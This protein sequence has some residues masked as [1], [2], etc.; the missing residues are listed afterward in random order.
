[1]ELMIGI[2]LLGMISISVFTL[3]TTLIR[4]TVITKRKAIA[5][6]LAIS[7][8]EALKALP[9]NSL[10]VAGGPIYSTT[11]LPASF[12]TTLNNISYTTT[13]AINYVDDAFD[14]CGSYPTLAL[15]QLYCRNYPPPTGTPATDTNPQDY[16]IANVTVFGPG[17][18]KLA[19]V[20]SQISA[21]VAETASSTGALFVSVLDQDGNPLAGATVQVLNTTTTPNINLSDTSD[22]NGTAI[23]YGLPPDTTGYDYNITGSLANYSTLSTIAPTGSLVPNYS[24]QRILT[25]QSSSVTLTLKAQGED[26]LVIE[27][28]TTTGAVLAGVKVYVKGGYKKY[29]STT[30]TSYYYDNMAPSDV[31]PT[32]DAGGLTS[33][34][35]LVPGPYV[36]CGELANSNCKIGNTTYYA[37]AV[38]PYGGINPF[39]P[40]TV[41]T[42]L[43]SSPPAVTY[44]YNGTEYLQKVRLMLTT[45][46]SF[47]RI[48]SLSPDDVSLSTSPLSSFSFQ[49]KGANLPCTGSPGT[50]STSVRF[51]QGSTTFTASCTGSGTGILL[52]CTVN[53]TGLTSAPTFLSVTSGGNTLSVPAGSYLGGLIVSP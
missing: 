13:T 17:N 8:M 40:I 51:V 10:A 31:R 47:P 20:D 44:N 37:A 26:S 9:F 46:S 5:S 11:Y 3:F 25:Q 19:E 50:C 33:L 6:T 2:L 14:G 29:T 41:P 43:A 38:I 24:N 21:R 36:F 23:F 16:K 30:D 53:L 7:Q 28:T 39:N 22:S 49:L 4:S 34:S 27:T 32:T 18:V 12:N 15:K 1:M 45:S 42:Y 35:N 48:Y 52:S